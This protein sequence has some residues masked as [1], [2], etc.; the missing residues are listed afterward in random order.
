MSMDRLPALPLIL[1]DPYFSIWC[2]ADTLTG[3]VTTHW[4]GAQKP[5]TGTALIDGTAYRF[6]GAGRDPEM[7]TVSLKVT[8]TATASTLEAG[9]VAVTVSFTT[10]LLLDRPDILSMPVTYVDVDAR[11]A[12]GEAHDVKLTFF[13]SDALCYETRNFPADPAQRAAS[14]DPG[15]PCLMKPFMLRDTYRHGDLNVAFTGKTHQ[16]VLGHSGD[17]ITMDWGYLYLAGTG[18]VRADEGGLSGTAQGAVT[19]DRAL[20]LNLY[21]A[22]DDVASINYFGRVT[23]AYYARGGMTILEAIDTF[24]NKR[25]TLTDACRALD[26]E[27]TKKACALGGEDYSLIVSAAYRHAIA[28]HK[29]IADENGDMIFLSKENNSNGCIGTVDVSYPSVPLFLLVNPEFV[30]GMCRPVLKFASLPVWTYDFAP[31]DVGRYPYATGQVYG[32]KAQGYFRGIHGLVYPPLYLYPGDAD[33]Y[34]LRGQMPVEECGNMLL[35]LAAA[36]HADGDYSLEKKYLPLLD[37]WVRYLIE[38]GEDP[39]EQLCT[40]D[41]AGHLA[42]NINLSAKALCGVAAYALILKGLGDENGYE[43]YMATARKMAKSWLERADAGGYTYLTF[44]KVGWSRKYNLVWDRLLGLNLL[45]DDF[46][47]KE[48]ESYL[49]RMNTYG[50]PLDS[51]SDYT[52]SD[53]ILWTASMADRETFRKIVSPVARYLRESESRVAFSDWYFTSTGRYRAFIA[54]SVQG[55]LFMPLL[56]DKWTETK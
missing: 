31:H 25:E 37:R 47:R 19:A 44:D 20:S 38:Y 45:G 17:G 3:A 42:R 35:M 15:Y 6:L 30:R 41:F 16:G 21:A 56:M 26:D 40:D 18:D 14:V 52:K 10:P 36:S 22:Y 11:S 28:A 43:T 4:T 46:Y 12:D 2:A 33:I 23:P 24:H 8:P 29:L 34:S 48:T 54:R 50:L 51:R 9:G 1:N 13:M 53:W 49:G 55:G 5:I 27:L 32:L 7:T 39:G